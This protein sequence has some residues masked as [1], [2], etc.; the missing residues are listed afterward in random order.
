MDPAL[1]EMTWI[2]D[3]RLS[4]SNKVLLG[5]EPET[6]QHILAFVKCIRGRSKRL[7]CRDTDLRN[8]GVVNTL[9]DA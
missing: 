1:I 6:L 8:V 4:P 2:T 9:K 5:N 7:H 3:W